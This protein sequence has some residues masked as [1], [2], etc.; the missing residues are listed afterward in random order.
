MMLDSFAETLEPECWKTVETKK[1]IAK[2]PLN[3]SRNINPTPIDKTLFA[4]FVTARN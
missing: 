1:S 4:G 3:C 2:T